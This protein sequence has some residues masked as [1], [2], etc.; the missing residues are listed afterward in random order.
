ME[1][2]AFLP[3]ALIAQSV[4]HVAPFV[5]ARLYAPLRLEAWYLR[6]TATVAAVLGWMMELTW[7]TSLSRTAEDLRYASTTFCIG[8]SSHPCARLGGRCSCKGG[9]PAVCD[10]LDRKRDRTALGRVHAHLRA[11]QGG[12]TNPPVL[13][14]I[15]SCDSN[16]QVV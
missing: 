8:G 13:T 14:L 6:S 5:L 12:P 1:C 15:H 3:G 2:I 7:L 10:R 4:G 16:A 11:R 9:I